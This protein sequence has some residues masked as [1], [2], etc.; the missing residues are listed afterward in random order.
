MPQLTDLYRYMFPLLTDDEGRPDVLGTAFIVAVGHFRFIVTAAHV[1]EAGNSSA[2]RFGRGIVA[3]PGSV[4]VV[5]SGMPPSGRRVD[6]R[7]DLAVWQADEQLTA[8]LLAQGTHPIEIESIGVG[9]LAES[10]DHYVFSGY[11]ASRTRTNRATREIDPGPVSANCLAVVDDRLVDLGL[12]RTTHIIGAFDRR[13]MA[14]LQ[15]QQITAPEPWGMSGGPVWKIQGNDC[16]LVGVGIE[17][18][19]GSNVLVAT[20][21]GAVVALLRASFPET[22]PFLSE[23][24]Y[25]TTR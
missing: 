7:V 20:R 14:N 3:N 13:R 2:L 11:P 21:L 25:F 18:L 23:P 5:T 19:E 9:D 1:V 24:E 17:Y 8:A 10:G 16:C 12:H 22:R 6:D 15:G 4:K